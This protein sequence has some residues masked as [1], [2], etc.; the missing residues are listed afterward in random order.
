MLICSRHDGTIVTERGTELGGG[1]WGGSWGVRGGESERLQSTDYLTPS[2]RGR[3]RR[4]GPY[5]FS[6]SPSRARQ[7]GAIASRVLGG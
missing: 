4:G 1:V 5:G 7:W 3:R 2:P 6:T